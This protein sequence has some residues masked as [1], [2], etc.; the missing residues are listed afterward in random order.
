MC[1]VLLLALAP[2]PA[3]SADAPGPVGGAPAKLPDLPEVD[4][5][6]LPVP[7]PVQAVTNLLGYGRQRLALVVGIGTIGSR[8]VV[9]S[10]PRDTLAVASALRAGGFIVMVRE[11]LSGRALRESL[12]E[13]RQRLDPGSIGL[14]YLTGLGVQI[15][16][17]NLLLPRDTPLDAARPIGPAA[18]RQAGI[19][20]QEV[21]EALMGPPDS[22]RLLVVDAA[23]LHPALAAL[24]KPGLAEPRLPPGTMALFGHALDQAQEVP[25]AAPLPTPM[26]TD[27]RDLAV[28]VFA[29][30]L[31]GAL[32]TPRISGAEALR[33][34]QRALSKGSEGQLQPWLGGDTD[35]R[36]DLAEATLLDGL[37]PRTPEEIAREA[38]RQASRPT[39][40]PGGV[41]SGVQAVAATDTSQEASATGDGAGSAGATRP[42]LPDLPKLTSG[43]L[44]TVTGVAG[45]TVT[46]ASVAAGA[47]VMQASAAVAA[48]GTAAGAATSVGGTAVALGSRLAG[49]GAA[50]T[51]ARL[52]AQQN[53][54]SGAAAGAGPAVAVSAATATAG[55]AVA[56]SGAPAPP[57][58]ARPAQL[59]LDGRTQRVAE[60][61]ERPAFIARTNNF[62]YA[63][64]D[65]FTYQITDLWKDEVNGSFTTAIEEVLG[66][67]ELMANGQTV[68]M[69]PQGRMKSQRLS[70]G[71]TSSFEPHEDLWWSY[72]KTGQ[73]RAVD[74][75]ERL[76]RPGQG[77]VERQFKG[78]ASVGRLRTIETP[79]GDFEALPIETQG[80]YHE[81]LPGGQ[82]SSGQ[83][84]RTVWYSPRFGHPVRIDIED[85]DAMGKLLR[86]ERVELT[87]AQQ[88]RGAP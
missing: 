85:I 23:Y 7:R 21:L 27:P 66:D 40:R 41:R 31:S 9:D 8:P 39:T 69:D 49:D 57:A 80:W 13:Y 19:P 32:V 73:E 14:V 65:T 4:K 53:V 45:A 81:K 68:L 33:A 52:A 70:D 71:S 42:G 79:A 60:G 6:R 75:T 28:S 2:G 34:T 78:S 48:A 38:I 83:F 3:W 64:G 50:E 84:S 82:T 10:A 22:P 62:G 61:G 16:G 17:Q 46:L 58:A 51:P 67:G 76:R 29:R 36:D 5:L 54:G 56:A 1:I 25:A 88:V 72:P 20:I 77:Q 47:Q 24:P 30:V 74:F 87:H 12:A 63:E 15:D 86:R 55:S 18:L 26:P 35:S 37:V 59:A 11:D 43:A 44:S